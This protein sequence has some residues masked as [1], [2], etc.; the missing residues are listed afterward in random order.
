MVDGVRID[1]KK[2][3]MLFLLYAKTVIIIIKI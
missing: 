1:I 2:C 3:L